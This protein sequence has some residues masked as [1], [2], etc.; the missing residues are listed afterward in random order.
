[1]KAGVISRAPGPK[2]FYVL[3]RHAGRQAPA[4]KLKTSGQALNVKAQRQRSLD[5]LNSFSHDTPKPLGVHW[6]S[7]G[8]LVSH[9][10]LRR[11]K[12]GYLRT[13]KVY[14]VTPS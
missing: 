12:D 10:Y 7:V 1:V 4:K 9:G 8:K 11:T 13:A 6:N 5:L 14:E 3:G 2:G